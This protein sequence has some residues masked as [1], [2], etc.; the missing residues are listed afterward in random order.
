[1]ISREGGW[2]GYSVVVIMENMSGMKPDKVSR[3]IL[4]LLKFVLYFRIFRTYYHIGGPF[5]V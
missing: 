2:G 3:F 5:N 4:I 1:M